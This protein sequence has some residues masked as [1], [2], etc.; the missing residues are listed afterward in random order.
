MRL[1]QSGDERMVRVELENPLPDRNRL[2]GS[3]VHARERRR[4]AEGV[5]DQ[6][7]RRLGQPGGQ[8]HLLDVLAQGLLQPGQ[9]VGEVL[10]LLLALGLVALVLLGVEVH[11]ALGDR[12][13]RFAVELGH[14]PTQTSSTGSVSS[15]TS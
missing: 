12:L 7:G 10:L 11:L 6:A 2:P 8:P 14:L 1:A 9:Q 13:Q 3:L 5:G 4:H 15:S